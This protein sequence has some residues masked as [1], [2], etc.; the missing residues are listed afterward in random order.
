M[1]LFLKCNL[2]SIL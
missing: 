2:L 1:N